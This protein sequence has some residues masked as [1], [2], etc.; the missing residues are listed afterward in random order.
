MNPLDSLPIIIDDLYDRID[1]TCDWLEEFYGIHAP[2]RRVTPY[3][4]KK[5]D[6]GYFTKI[7]PKKRK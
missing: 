3:A 7:E 6:P 1:H 2:H 4:V 5:I